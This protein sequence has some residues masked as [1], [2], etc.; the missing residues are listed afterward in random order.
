MGT[1]IPQGLLAFEGPSSF[2]APHTDI[3]TPPCETPTDPTA[4]VP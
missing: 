4:L 2:G 1:P 3:G